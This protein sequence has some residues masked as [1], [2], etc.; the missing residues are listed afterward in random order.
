M[1]SIRVNSITTRKFIYKEEYGDEIFLNYAWVK[2]GV[3]YRHSERISRPLPD[4][5]LI[6]KWKTF[7]NKL[8]PGQQEE[9]TVTINRPMV[10]RL[11]LS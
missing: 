5:N 4:K 6:V 2:N 3:L 9:W 1:L 7:R 11:M 10:R 8:T